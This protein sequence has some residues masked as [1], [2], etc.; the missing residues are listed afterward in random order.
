MNGKV[1][2]IMIGMYKRDSYQSREF[3]FDL[4]TRFHFF[5]I[6]DYQNN[7]MGV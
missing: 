6:I 4:V 5:F 1:S 7:E 2:I 3:W